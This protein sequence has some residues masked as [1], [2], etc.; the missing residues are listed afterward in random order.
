MVGLTAHRLN[1]AGQ[2]GDEMDRADRAIKSM[3]TN[4][5]A[6]LPG[7]PSWSLVELDTAD[8]ERDAAEREAQYHSEM[9]AE[10]GPQASEFVHLP[11]WGA[12]T[13]WATINYLGG[14]HPADC[15]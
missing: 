13:H 9:A 7:R 15:L 14:E 1:E 3:M 11:D 8:E 6:A 2:I 12:E 4:R 5:A 10:A